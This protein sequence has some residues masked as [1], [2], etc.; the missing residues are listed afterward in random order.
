LTHCVCKL[1]RYQF[2]DKVWSTRELKQRRTDAA[3]PQ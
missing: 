3:Y 1:K 2:A